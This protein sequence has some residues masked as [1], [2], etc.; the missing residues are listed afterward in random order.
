[1]N[2]WKSGLNSD[3]SELSSTSVWSPLPLEVRVVFRVA[4]WS[5]SL[6]SG[7]LRFLRMCRSRLLW[8][9]LFLAILCGLGVLYGLSTS[10]ADYAYALGMD[11]SQ[12]IK[13][14]IDNLR[15]AAKYNPFDHNARTVGASL[16]AL[17]AL[18]S[19]DRGWLEAARAEVRY[20]LQTD[21][22]DAVL[23]IRGLLVNLDLKDNR[24]A[25][26]YFDQFQRVDRKSPL[27]KQ[28]EQAHIEGTQNVKN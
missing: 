11:E 17:V 28:V 24:E 10:K 27:I 23:L 14:R 5:R 3:S 22:T 7:C 21:S 12:P 25:Q 9:R 13:E 16:M 26:F 18:T 6:L 4:S 8:V 15:I 2:L 19:H 20:R 1:M